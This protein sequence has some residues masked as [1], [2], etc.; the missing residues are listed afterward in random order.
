MEV[1]RKN[2]CPFHFKF[3]SP[4]QFLPRHDVS[5]RFVGKFIAQVPHSMEI[6]ISH[7]EQK[8]SWSVNILNAISK[9][10]L[11]MVCSNGTEEIWQE[12]IITCNK[13][14]ENFSDCWLNFTLFIIIM[15]IKLYNKR[16][17]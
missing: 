12:L 2:S 4:L 7:R 17:L 11:V 16:P 13:H 15:K 6:F 3:P 5:T 8:D 9:A 14:Q 1:R 10:T